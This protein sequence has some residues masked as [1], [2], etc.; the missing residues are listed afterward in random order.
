VLTRRTLDT[1]LLAVGVLLLARVSSVVWLR[2]KLLPHTDALQVGVWLT[3][4]RWCDVICVVDIDFVA[5]R[6]IDRGIARNTNTI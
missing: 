2:A 3:R 5:E 1:S 4:A 6:N